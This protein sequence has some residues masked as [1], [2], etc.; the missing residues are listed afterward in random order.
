[1]PATAQQ[2]HK[3]R[4]VQ[5]LTEQWVQRRLGRIAHERR[6]VSIASI[7]FDLT[8]SL[9]ELSADDRRSLVLAA[10]VHDVGRKINDKRHP[11][12][13]ARMILADAH[14]PLNDSQR[15]CLAYLTRYHR[16]A[17]PAVG[18]DDILSPGDNR[19][20]MRLLLAL[21]RAAD[22]LDGRQIDAPRLVFAMKAR[23]LSIRCYFDDP[24]PKAKR[25]F[26]R[27]K[28]FR[29]LEELLNCRVDVSVRQADSVHAVA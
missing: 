27:R 24:S 2:Q 13:G 10:L 29:L 5:R 14:L 4:R 21:L 22:A 1:M 23:K 26:K 16:G 3:H 9:H 11:T 15:R 25:F 7:L 28:K 19:K 18:Y 17:V 6:V 20:R 12:I 8:R